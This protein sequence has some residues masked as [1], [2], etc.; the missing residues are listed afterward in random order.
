MREEEVTLSLTYQVSFEVFMIINEGVFAVV[1]L[2]VGVPEI[3]NH[4]LASGQI[5][6]CY[7]ESFL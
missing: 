3:L 6:R 5:P 2:L 7:S 4:C 1:I